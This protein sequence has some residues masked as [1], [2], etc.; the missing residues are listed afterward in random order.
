MDLSLWWWGTTDHP[1]NLGPRNN[2]GDILSPNIFRHYGVHFREAPSFEEANIIS[3]GSVARLAKDGDTVIGSGVNSQGEVLNPD[4]RWRAVR[5]PL[6]WEAVER[7]GGDCP[8]IFGD[9]A[10]LLPRLI[11]PRQTRYRLG[12]VPHYLHPAH[13]PLRRMRRINVVRD[14]PLE[15]AS[16][17][18]ECD[19]IISS[20]LHGIICAHAFGIPA[21]WVP[22]RKVPGDGAKFHDHCASVGIEAEQSTIRKPKFS[23]PNQIDLS[24]LEAA[25]DQLAEDSRTDA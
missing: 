15:V 8:K 19:A 24:D 6:T 22:Y 3:I 14:D 23:C 11:E 4:A 16:E 7:G 25:F 2:F 21:A 17:I 13:L 5:G 1:K 20:S 9:P 12:F 18:T 10:L